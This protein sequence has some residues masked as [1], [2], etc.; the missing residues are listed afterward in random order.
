[1]TNIIFAAVLVGIA[2]KCGEMIGEVVVNVIKAICKAIMV[3]IR[4]ALC[5]RKPVSRL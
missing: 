5:S 2:Y 1:M 3:P 4:A